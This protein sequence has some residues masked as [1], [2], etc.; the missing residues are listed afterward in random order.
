MSL[1][2]LPLDIQRLL[3]TLVDSKQIHFFSE[4]RLRR[5]LCTKDPQALG[6]AREKILRESGIRN[7]I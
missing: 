2:T 1:L 4:R 5:L 7:S 6:Y 3:E